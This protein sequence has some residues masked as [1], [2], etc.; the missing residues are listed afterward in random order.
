M[1]EKWTQ[2]IN[3]N[4]LALASLYK[5]LFQPLLFISIKYTHDLEISRDI[6]SE[7][8][9]ALLETSLEDRSKKWKKVREVKAFLTIIIRNKSIDAI[10]TKTNRNK[11][12]NDW[13][14][15]QVT[16]TENDYIYEDYIEKCISHLND[17]EK[18]LILLHLDGYKNQEIGVKFNHTEK[19]I[20]NKLSLSRK[21]LVYFWK[22]LI[23]LI[24]WSILS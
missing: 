5:N 23:I 21:K 9:T 14:K 16:K 17:D 8:F 22:N 19:T 13:I 15:N 24:V 4:D 6:V 1:N 2:F 3:G 20:R 7:L 18:V 10:R 11:L 12:G